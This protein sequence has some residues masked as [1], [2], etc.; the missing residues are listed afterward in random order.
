MHYIQYEELCR[1]YIAN[2]F[3]ISIEEVKS[4]RIP[5]PTHPDLVEYKNQIDLYWILE[6]EF[7]QYINIADAKWRKESDTVPIGK[8]R[9]LQFVRDDINN[10][11][12]AILITNTGFD[13]GVKGVADK[14]GMGLHI[15]RPDF[16]PAILDP[17]LKDRKVIQTQLQEL[18]ANGKEIYTYQ[19]I[20][21]AFDLG[22]DAETQSGVPN[23][24]VSHSKEI[25]KTPMNRIA[26][27]T[28]HQRVPSGTQKVQGRRGSPQTGGRR[29]GV[30][31]RMGPPRGG[32]GGSNRG[33]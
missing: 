32:G 11:N 2:I 33:R 19:I 1:L 29:E 14:Y 17:D 8:A 5:S 10:A 12:K 18:S 3:E 31:N 24:T 15:V 26:Q 23:E 30:Q 22:T 16:D 20:H 6:N 28:S 7:Y 21:R 25:R 4:V 9:E 27:P 13:D